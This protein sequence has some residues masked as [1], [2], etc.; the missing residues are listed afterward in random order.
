MI[1][2]DRE[3]IQEA[4]DGLMH[5]EGLCNEESALYDDGEE[6]DK[7]SYTAIINKETGIVIPLCHDCYQ[8]QP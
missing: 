7:K 4:K 6:C 1:K 5:C 3:V 8:S 2:S